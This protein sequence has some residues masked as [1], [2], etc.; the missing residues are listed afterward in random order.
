MSEEKKTAST[1]SLSSAT[2]GNSLSQSEIVDLLQQTLRQLDGIVTKLN[3]ESLET[4]P[5]KAAIESLVAMTEALANSL[6]TSPVEVI[7]AKEAIPATSSDGTSDSTVE[8]PPL[9]FSKAKL[10]IEK[11]KDSLPVAVNETDSPLPSPSS[12]PTEPGNVFTKIRSLLPTWGLIGIL[13]GIV[14]ILLLTGVLFFTRP[15]TEVAEKPP[16][17]IATPPELIAPGQPK[18]L[19]I[20]PP[21]QPEL[22]PE[23]SLIAAIQEQV[24]D[25]TSRYSE[26]LIV[27]IE[28]NFLASRLNVTVGEDWYQLSHSR[29]DKL[30]NDILKR[31][32]KLDFRK[33]RIVDPDGTLIARNPVVGNNI[34]IMQRER[35]AIAIE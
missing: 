29:Q 9:E 17:A 32:Q 30:A 19:E 26:K 15:T 7:G 8:T 31:S 34:V 21:P 10:P 14:T 22:T 5:P 4:L 6:K 16:E 2:E 25:I 3:A 11:G 18:P 12:L 23:Q 35:S 27:S 1:S 28:A 13:V 20:A 24:A 33:L